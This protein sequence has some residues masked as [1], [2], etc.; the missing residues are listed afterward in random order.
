[1]GD[2]SSGVRFGNLHRWVWGL[3]TVLN[4]GRFLIC[5]T[6]EDPPDFQKKTKSSHRQ[7]KGWR[8]VKKVI[9]IPEAQ[10]TL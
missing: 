3:T 7:P 8:Q 9:F 6:K 10:V 5:T 4:G 1:M 2:K